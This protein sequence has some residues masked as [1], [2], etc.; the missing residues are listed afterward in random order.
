MGKYPGSATVGV[1]ST[2]RSKGAR[3]EP[4]ESWSGSP[5]GGQA[6]DGSGD[7]AAGTGLAQGFAAGHLGEIKAPLFLLP[8]FDVPMVPPI[9]Q[10]RSQSSWGPG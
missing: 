9:G 5:L 7:I 4:L 6:S 2:S 8:V 3:G 1:V 10:P